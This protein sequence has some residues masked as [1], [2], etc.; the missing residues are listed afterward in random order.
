MEL[1]VQQEVPITV[2][3]FTAIP[4]SDVSI[5][6]PS[7]ENAI[8]EK[9]GDNR[10]YRVKHNG[11]KYN[12]IEQHYV[13]FPEQAGDLVIPPVILQ[14]TMPD[15]EQTTRN[16]PF[17]NDLF[18]EPFF[19]NAFGGN[20]QIQRM[21]RGSSML[22]GRSG[23]PLTLRS[24]GLKFYVQNIPIAAQGNSWLPARNVTLN[25]SWES[26]PPTLKTGEPATMTITL[27][28][29]GLTSA[30][31]PTLKIEDK[32][33]LYR[34]YAD[35]I[36][37]ENLTD[38]E[39]VTGV[40]KQS[41]TIIP[42]KSGVLN[43]P[44]IKQ[45]WWNT[46]SNTLQTA[47]IYPMTLN[48][49]QGAA[50]NDSNH[51]NTPDSNNSSS[52]INTGNHF[53]ANNNLSDTSNVSKLLTST[54]QSRGFAIVLLVIILL[55]LSWVILRKKSTSFVTGTQNNNI[56]K[57]QKLQQVETRQRAESFLKQAVSACE[58]GN[59][60][61][62]AQFILQWSKV[63]W[64]E[65]TPVSLL[66]VADSIIQ[67]STNIRQLHQFLYQPQENKKTWQD[68]ELAKL[69]QKGLQL[70]TRQNKHFDKHNLPP[71][72]PA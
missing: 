15:T 1:M 67:G 59:A 57:N 47:E 30:N 4:L 64:P 3:L 21:L 38:G 25:S 35:P 34:L 65:L 5:S 23:K 27:K 7:P 26:N 58:S 42:E 45:V 24:D 48:V 43:F 72:Y 9:L 8:T 13:V 55:L 66:D 40:S 70:R 51:I 29:E 46:Q 16:S 2:R 20:G 18:N 69:L 19:K 50:I 17:T 6:K 49:T 12:V 61:Q 11:R 28:A 53:K 31:I 39:T 44:S 56:I 36:E 22:F 10:Q 71:L 62:A 52:S 37:S 54:I 60:K 68:R 33:G 63:K 32:P 41:F 14:A